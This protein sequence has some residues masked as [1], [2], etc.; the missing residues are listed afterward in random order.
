MRTNYLFSLLIAFSLLLFTGCPPQSTVAPPDA[1]PKDPETI[2]REL[3]EG[4]GGTVSKSKDNRLIG[5]KFD[6][7][8]KSTQLTVDDM[9]SI[10]KLTDLESLELYG[11]QINDSFIAELTPLKKLKN[12]QIENTSITNKSL[13]IL[14]EF[15][16]IRILR[17]QRNMDI[18]NDAFDILKDFPKLTD[19]RM[20]HSNISSS[21][22]FDLELLKNLKSL[23]ARA[24][25]VDN[26]VLSLLEGLTELEI[27]KLSGN[28]IGDEGIASLAEN[29]KKL[30]MIEL[31][32]TVISSESATHFSEMKNLKGLK[33]FRAD[34]F[35]AEGVAGLGAI[36]G[37]ETLELRNMTAS[38]DA[39]LEL[40]NLKNLTLL[41]LS[42]LRGID[43][44]IAII[45]LMKALPKLNRVDFFAMPVDDSLAEQL[46]KMDGLKNISLRATSVSDKGLEALA[47]LPNLT[48]LHIGANKQRIT[49]DGAISA[50][51]KYKSLKE[52]TV[53]ETLGGD[54]KFM[55]AM[56]KA[57]PNCV[58]KIDTYS[59]ET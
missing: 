35:G 24:L 27:I 1:A 5:I 20:L 17:L 48:H 12:V 43:D 19:L 52:L 50:L 18:D 2:V 22:I 13:E 58:I 55:D 16:E 39:I 4:L 37:L 10:A 49:V 9:K 8:S 26:I 36:T 14:K 59:Q 30:R 38:N 40:K 11:D 47:K 23:D 33:I 28:A 32:D 41:Q 56:K 25:P 29:N 3:V 7:N 6:I 57:L 53:P 54:K 34:N 21:G 31:Q 51:T 15:P 42:E 45:E 44:S 46:S